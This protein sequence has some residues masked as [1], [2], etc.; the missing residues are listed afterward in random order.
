MEQIEESCGGCLLV[1]IL[2]GY[3]VAELLTHQKMQIVIE[4]LQDSV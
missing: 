4:A 2:S 1:R 3:T